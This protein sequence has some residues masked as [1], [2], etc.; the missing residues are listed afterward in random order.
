MSDVKEFSDTNILIYAYSSTENDKRT[1]ALAILQHPLTLSI[2]VVN[3]FHWV[4]SRKYQVALAQLQAV[5]RALFTFYQIQPIGQ[6]TIDKALQLAQTHQY[7]YWDSLIIAA[8]LEAECAILYSEDMQHGQLIE[9][10]L[11]IV[12]PFL[13]SDLAIEQCP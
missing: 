12:N 9:Q 1:R 11:N 8:A 3:E 7:S 13:E 10:Q 5:N 6:A 2:Q 4:M